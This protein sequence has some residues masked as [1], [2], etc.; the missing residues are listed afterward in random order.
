MDLTHFLRHFLKG[1]NLKYNVFYTTFSG[2]FM[3]VCVECVFFYSSG[4]PPSRTLV[5]CSVVR[6]ESLEVKVLRLC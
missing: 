6:E 1:N 5:F 2:I 3:N 4:A